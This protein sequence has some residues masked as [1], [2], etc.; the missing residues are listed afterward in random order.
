M[1]TNYSYN[2]VIPTPIKKREIDPN[3]KKFK[4][5]VFDNVKVQGVLI[6]DR[7]WD[8]CFETSFYCNVS[9]LAALHFENTVD[10]Q[11]WVIKNCLG[12]S[13]IKKEIKDQFE[14]LQKYWTYD[15]DI[16]VSYTHEHSINSFSFKKKNYLGFDLKLSPKPE[17]YS[18]KNWKDLYPNYEKT[19]QWISNL[20]IFK[21]NEYIQFSST[22]KKVEP[23]KS[24]T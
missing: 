5:I 1:I 11:D 18:T 23:I 9:N 12:I 19:C 13:R 3:Y 16:F 2:D 6:K 24:N 17:T 20:N 22:S 8:I 15:P 10:F 7:E 21:E 14:P 4:S